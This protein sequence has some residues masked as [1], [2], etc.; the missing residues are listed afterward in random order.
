ME[1]PPTEQEQNTADRKHYAEVGGDR[2][3]LRTAGC[4]DS[5]ESEIIHVW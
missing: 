1:F 2:L 5:A 4:T 3:R